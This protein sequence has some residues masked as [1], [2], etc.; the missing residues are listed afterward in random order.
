MGREGS[1]WRRAQP[2]GWPLVDVL[3]VDAR[4]AVQQTV[5]QLHHFT[6][7]NRDFGASVDVG[8]AHIAVR[9]DLSVTLPTLVEPP[10]RPTARQP[11]WP[12]PS[13]RVLEE[14]VGTVQKA[15]S[16][17]GTRGFGYGQR[18][19]VLRRLV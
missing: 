10:P 1:S 2:Q 6:S 12:S 11:R 13:F 8:D 4:I 16:V 3:T 9:G 18:R 17:V 5:R 7:T 14:R 19:P 15:F